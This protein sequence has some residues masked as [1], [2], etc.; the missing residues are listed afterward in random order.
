MIK[1]CFYPSGRYQP[2]TPSLRMA[3]INLLNVLCAS[4]YYGDKNIIK[5]IIMFDLVHHLP[6]LTRRTRRGFWNTQE[7]AGGDTGGH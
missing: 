3:I 1:R 4:E 2:S 6:F 7:K 5:I